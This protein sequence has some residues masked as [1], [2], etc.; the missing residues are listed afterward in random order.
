MT[1]ANNILAVINGAYVNGEL[2]I[3]EDLPLGERGDGLADFLRNEVLDITQGIT[4]EEKAY[5]ETIVALINVQDQIQC[6]V[7]AMESAA[8][9]VSDDS[10]DLGDDEIDSDVS[11]LSEDDAQMISYVEANMPGAMKSISDDDL[12]AGCAHL[13]YQPGELS[14]CRKFEDNYEWPAEFDEDGYAQE[15]DKMIPVKNIED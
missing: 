10:C 14:Y 1:I 7:S 6:I 13:I 12:C 4:S 15:C 2:R 11:F 3:D 9:H 5:H 8:M